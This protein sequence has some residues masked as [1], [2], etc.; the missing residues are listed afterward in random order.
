MSIS[1]LYIIFIIAGSIDLLVI[2]ERIDAIRGKSKKTITDDKPNQTKTT[3]ITNLILD[4][5]LAITF[6]GLPIMWMVEE[7]SDSSFFLFFFSIISLV[8][9]TKMLLS[10][11]DKKIKIASFVISILLS[12]LLSIWAVKYISNDSNNNSNTPG[13][14]SI[15]GGSLTC[16]ICGEKGLYCENASYGSG[17]DH[18]CSKH[19]A[20]CVEWHEKHK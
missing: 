16:A 1:D 8:I 11:K 19:W 6:F 9:G 15:C 20:K 18:Y 5:I 13:V 12:A 17:S 7:Y 10:N 3:A 2:K 14:C 4:L